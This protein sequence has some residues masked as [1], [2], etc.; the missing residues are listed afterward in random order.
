MK[1]EKK[2]EEERKKRPYCF[3]TKFQV[4]TMSWVLK[5]LIN[6][7]MNFKRKKV[8]IYLFYSKEK[9]KDKLQGN[10]VNQ[11]KK[12]IRVSFVQRFKK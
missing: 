10:T 9:Q 3:E 5:K 1:D 6:K 12:T 7:K 11:E 8:G 4:H 2:E